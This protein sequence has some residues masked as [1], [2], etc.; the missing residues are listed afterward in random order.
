VMLNASLVLRLDPGLL[1]RIFGRNPLMVC[2]MEA[3][4]DKGIR[5]SSR[6]TLTVPLE[7]ALASKKTE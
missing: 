6:M 2:C 7:T 5:L 3:I 1:Y 4:V